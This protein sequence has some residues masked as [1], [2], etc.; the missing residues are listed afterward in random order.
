MDSNS[1]NGV[2]QVGFNVS[3]PLRSFVRTVRAVVIDPGRFFRELSR[4]QAPNNPVLFAGVCLLISY[5]LPELLTLL[6]PLLPDGLD[7]ARGLGWIPG[8]GLGSVAAALVLSIFTLPVIYS[9]SRFSTFS[10]RS[11]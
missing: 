5:L 3:S 8:E 1:G 6:N 10:S 9:S 7:F 4:Q 11:S 2:A